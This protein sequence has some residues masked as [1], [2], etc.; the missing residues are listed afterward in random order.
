MHHYTKVSR[1]VDPLSGLDW[2]VKCRHGNCGFRAPAG[3]EL[4]CKRIA[5]DHDQ[6]HLSRWAA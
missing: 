2:H 6:Y 3:D 5:R 4:A 1:K